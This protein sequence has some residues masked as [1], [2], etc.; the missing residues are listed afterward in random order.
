MSLDSELIMK[1]GEVIGTQAPTGHTVLLDARFE[2]PYGE[3]I[4]TLAYTG[5]YELDIWCQFLCR[6]RVHSRNM[7]LFY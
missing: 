5:N 7:P 2:L 1:N 3:N 4:P 6:N